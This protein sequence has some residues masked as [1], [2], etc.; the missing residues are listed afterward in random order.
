MEKPRIRVPA[1]TQ[2]S[3]ANF[4]A[5][6]GIGTDNQSSGGSYGFNF[7]TRNRTQLEAAYRGSWIVGQAVDAPADDMTR[8]GV[9]IESTLGPD[10]EEKLQ[11]SLADLMVW[12]GLANVIRWARLFG[13]AIGIVLIDG[14]ELHTPLVLDSIGKDQFKGLAVLDRWMVQPTLNDLITDLGPTLGFPTF[15]DVIGTTTGLSGRRIHHSRVIRMI[16]I[17]LPYYHRLYEQM[18]GESVVERIYDRLLAFDSTTQGTAQLVY[19]AHLRTLKVDK[20]RE[21][22]ATGG[23]PME[24]F[25]QQIDMIRRFQTNEGLTLLDSTDEMAAISYN[26]AGIDGVLLQFGQQLAGALEVPLVR[27]FGQ[28]PA[29]LNSTGESDFRN[30]YDGINKRQERHLRRPLTMLLDVLCR[31]TLGKAAPD[32]FRFRFRPLWQTS[33]AEKAETGSKMTSAIQ[34]A[35]TGGLIDKAT[36]L[37]ELRATARATGMWTNITDEAITDAEAEPP[38]AEGAFDDPAGGGVGEE[39]AGGA[40]KGQT[41]AHA[42]QGHRTAV[43]VHT[44]QGD[45]TPIRA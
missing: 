45:R 3:F 26:F 42:G 35:F 18:W 19:K 4:Q 14:Q 27:L 39:A 31:S 44:G 29:G 15:Y 32:G 24:A 6:V 21:I 13:G 38:M 37:K 20:L 34:G 41:V 23:K 40:V 17:D 30:Y 16:G 12:Q 2:D 11:A 22:I 8:E 28:S 7:L 36:A 43:T 25:V 33:E 5:K 10:D 1:L 9:E